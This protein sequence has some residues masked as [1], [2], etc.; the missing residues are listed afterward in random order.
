MYITKESRQSQYLSFISHRHHFFLLLDVLVACE[1]PA[2][3]ASWAASTAS[4]FML[5]EVL[6]GTAID[7]PALSFSSTSSVLTRLRLFLEE[8][9]ADGAWSSSGSFTSSPSASPSW[10]GHSVPQPGQALEAYICR[11]ISKPEMA[12]TLTGVTVLTRIRRLPF[13]V[14]ISS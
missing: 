1:A 5:L 7:G 2:E 6:L 3:D 11:L 8:W 14:K 4:A 12:L 13:A 9:L 10:R